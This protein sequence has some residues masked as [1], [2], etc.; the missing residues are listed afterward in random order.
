MKLRQGKIIK[1]NY[2]L[3]E[4]SLIPAVPSVVV[5]REDRELWMHGTIIEYGEEEHNGW[6]YK[7]HITKMDRIV[8][9]NMRYDKWILVSSEQYLLDQ[10]AKNNE[11]SHYRDDIY[12][13]YGQ[14]MTK[15]TKSVWPQSHT[16]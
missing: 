4:H 15:P 2:T 12:R 16:Y 3:K 7:I 14:K 6:S 5:Q 1:N 9:R 13:Q 11:K 10:T 8:M